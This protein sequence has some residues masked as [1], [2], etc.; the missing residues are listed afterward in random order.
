MA[1]G[2]DCDDRDRG[3]HPSL[4]EL[5]DTIDQDCD[6]LIDEQ[7]GGCGAPAR[8]AGV[9][10]RAEDAAIAVEG[11]RVTAYD[12]YGVVLDQQPTRANG[13]FGLDVPSGPVVV[14]VEP[15]EASGL[16][17]IVRVILAPAT[18]LAVPLDGAARWQEIASAARVER[19]AGTG[20]L[21]AEFQGPTPAGGQGVLLAPGGGEARARIGTITVDGPLLPEYGPPQFA[22]EGQPFA[23]VSYYNL[24]PGLYNPMLTEESSLAIR[25]P[26]AI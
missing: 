10:A 6:G 13:R 14:S 16:V 12:L 4:R 18:G 20:L 19:S 15:P 22:P 24:E 11:A 9:V 5:C 3:V 26:C 8:V 7:L 2:G 23:S 25:T 1:I 17:G 21:V